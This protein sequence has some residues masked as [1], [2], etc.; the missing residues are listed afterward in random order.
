MI[1]FRARH[2]LVRATPRLACAA[3]A[4]WL[5]TGSAEAQSSGDVIAYVDSVVN[6]SVAA[7]RTAGASVAVVK[8]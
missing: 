2:Y 6:A 1:S 7:H 4:A 8:A 3:L 5:C